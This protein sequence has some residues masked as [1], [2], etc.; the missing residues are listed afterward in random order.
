M[1]NLAPSLRVASTMMLSIQQPPA[2]PAAHNQAPAAG[3]YETG[4]TKNGHPVLIAY[5]HDAECEV[6]HGP[7]AWFDLETWLKSRGVR[8][9]AFRPAILLLRGLFLGGCELLYRSAGQWL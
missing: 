8:L 6:A 9:T 5:D 7:T 2:L 1:Y 3:I 4:G